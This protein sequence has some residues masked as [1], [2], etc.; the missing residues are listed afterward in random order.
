MSPTQ[1]GQSSCKI[2]YILHIRSIF[3]QDTISPTH[4][5]NIP[6]RYYISYT[7]GQYSCKILYI[8]HIRSIF[9]KDT[10]RSVFLLNTVKSHHITSHHIT[11]HHITSHHITSHHITS[12]HITSH[13]ITSHHISHLTRS[14]ISYT[15][16][17]LSF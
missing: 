17:Q 6:A 13:H 1:T 5:V 7:S 11:S 4:Q 9:L 2:L 14:C 15:S 8:L 16:C 10:T 12:H 3:L